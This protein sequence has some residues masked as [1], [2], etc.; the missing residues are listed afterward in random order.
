MKNF[1]IETVKFE[2]KNY[3]TE[4]INLTNLENGILKN[5]FSLIIGNNGTGKSRFLSAICRYFV[6]LHLYQSNKNDELNT[7]KYSVK[8]TK[9]I[10]L[11]HGISDKF[12]LDKLFHPN[13]YEEDLKYSK[14]DYVYLGGRDRT[15]NF[16]SRVLINRA[17]DILFE[18]YIKDTVSQSYRHVFD[19]LDYEPVIKLEYQVVN[20]IKRDNIF[21]DNFITI[22][23][24]KDYLG[25][26]LSRGNIGFRRKKVETYIKNENNELENICNFY[27]SVYM[28]EKTFELIIN[29]S[30]NNISKINDDNSIYRDNYNNY[31]VLKL[32]KDIDLV[33]GFEVKVYKKGGNEFNFSDA[34]SG[35]ANILS[36]LIA[37]V[38]LVKNNSLILIDEPEISLHPSWQYQYIGLLQ[39]L[40]SHVQGCHVIIA[41]HSHFL[42]S[43]LPIEASSVIAF[44]NEKG[45]IK[46]KTIEV[47]T[48]GWS[49]EDILLNI[50]GL[51]TSRNYYLSLIVTEALEI[52]ASEKKDKKKFVEIRGELVRIVDL[53][54]EYDPLKKVIQLIINQEI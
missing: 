34:S 12:P 45:I 29:F 28:R 44:S 2:T 20:L 17:I 4:T 47:P 33:R 52:L 9:V 32:M 49:A 24:L 48:F 5:Y 27:N 39:K 38:P 36:T 19:Y 21:D 14:L 7:I 51:P 31:K 6:D 43:D 53:L 50:F 23:G 10:A 37:L 1:Q 3:C 18:N 46:G 25:S 26:R 40:L 15:H 35:E 11:S 54:K 16:S 42:V 41:T 22:S 8:P 30:E 13:K